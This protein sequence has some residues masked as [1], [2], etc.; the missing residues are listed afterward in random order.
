MS[1]NKEIRKSH[2]ILG[3]REAQLKQRP[4]DLRLCFCGGDLI[5]PMVRSKV[6]CVILSKSVME[7][8]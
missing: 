1:Q 8:P 5:G 7:P 6:C 2:P 4:R 3:R